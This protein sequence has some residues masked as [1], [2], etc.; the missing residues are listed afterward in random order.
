MTSRPVAQASPNHHATTLDA[1]GE[2]TSPF[3]APYV[4]PG[5]ANMESI[6][7]QNAHLKMTNMTNSFALLSGGSP[8][9]GLSHGEGCLGGHPP[10]QELSASLHH[11]GTIDGMSVDSSLLDH[12]AQTHSPLASPEGFLGLG[13]GGE[14]H[15]FV[16][17]GPSFLSP[18]PLTQAST[19]SRTSVDTPSWIAS[20]AHSSGMWPQ[21]QNLPPQHP[22]STEQLQDG[23]TSPMF[24]ATGYGGTHESVWRPGPSVIS[25]TPVLPSN[26]HEQSDNSGDSASLEKVRRRRGR[27]RLYGDNEIEVSKRKPGRP[28]TYAPVPDSFGSRSSMTSSRSAMS[29]SSAEDSTTPFWDGPSPSGP[30]KRNN[31]ADEL[32]EQGEAGTGAQGDVRARSKAA[33][34]RYR[35]KTQMTVERMEAEE[36][37]VS[38]RRQALLACADRLRTELCELKTEVM[39]HANCGCPHINGYISAVTQ[40]ALATMTGSPASQTPVSPSA[41]QLSGEISTDSGSQEPPSASAYPHSRFHLADCPWPHGGFVEGAPVPSAYH[42]SEMM[43]S[44]HVGHTMADVAGYFGQMPSGIA[45]DGG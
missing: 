39:Q 18:P 32:A 17:E 38:L 19:W 24:S 25:K 40:R 21:R 26:R 6:D 8:L 29:L 31:P 4:S 1:A 7:A 15:F 45:N 20:A 3:G 27:P 41:P 11:A 34:T 2:G 42:G 37:E 14:G 28:L 5:M 16:P 30:A 43:S 12:F 10:T 23:K 33:A 22:C 9:V 44:D 13:S 35:L 36:R